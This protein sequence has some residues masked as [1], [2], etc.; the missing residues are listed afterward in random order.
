MKISGISWIFLKHT[1]NDVAPLL[2]CTAWVAVPLSPRCIDVG[3]ALERRWK[4]WS[5]PLNEAACSAVPYLPPSGT[6]ASEDL[7]LRGSTWAQ[8]Y[9][10]RDF[11]QNIQSSTA[12]RMTGRPYHARYW[13]R[14]ILYLANQL[15]SVSKS[16]Y[17]LVR[18]D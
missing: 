11:F 9:F 16:G 4:T 3:P 8:H 6:L 13:T 7:I 2:A 15:V 12:E 5:W 18:S 10:P 1:K 17:N 14:R